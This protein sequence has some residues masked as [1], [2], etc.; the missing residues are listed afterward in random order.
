MYINPSLVL[1]NLQKIKRDL[2]A[3]F[4]L[5][6]HLYL[7]SVMHTICDDNG[8]MEGECNEATTPPPSTTTQTTPPTTPPSP[9]PPKPYKHR[10]P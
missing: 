6:A 8:N 3:N 2:N 7:M 5:A 9:P 4:Q 10:H 1:N